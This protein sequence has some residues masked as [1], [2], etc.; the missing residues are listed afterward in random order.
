MFKNKTLCATLILM[1]TMLLCSAMTTYAGQP[2]G[3]FDDFEGNTIVG[4]GWDSSTPNT[5]I[6]VQ[7]TVMNKDTEEVVGNFQ[8][9]A[10]TY[11]SDLKENG[12]GNGNH[13]FRI[14]MNWDSLPDGTYLIEGWADTHPFGNTRTYVKGETKT[15]AE[16]TSSQTST[17]S[18]SVA[19]KMRSLGIFRTTGYCP[20]YQCS[21]GWG[22]HTCTGATARSGHT[23]AVDPRVIPYG[24]KVMI[25]GVVYTAEDRG[26]GVKGNHVDIFFDSH[27][28]T[29]QHGSQSEEVFLLTN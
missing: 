8:P 27:S 29:R 7:I 4:W 10:I 24:S 3:Y 23:I 14:N 22:R 12:I 5:A 13:G 17:E 25:G 1:I 16:D 28:Q 21:E 18:V 9:T 2:S 6:P 19:S 20:C 15:A 11:R 26:G